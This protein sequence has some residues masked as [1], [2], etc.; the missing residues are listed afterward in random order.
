MKMMIFFLI[1]LFD[2]PMTMSG[3]WHLNGLD[4]PGWGNKTRKFGFLENKYQWNRGHWKFLDEVDEKME[5]YEFSKRSRFVDREEEHFT[6][7]YLFDRGIDFME[8]AMSRNQS[9]AYVLSIPGEFIEKLME[10]GNSI[11]IDICTYLIGLNFSS[12]T[13]MHPT[14][15]VH[16]TTLCIQI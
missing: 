15:I 2:D 11:E 8:T 1:L 7:D 16:R 6:T 10:M 3:K 14:K 9:F 5:A 12:K 13:L 4:K